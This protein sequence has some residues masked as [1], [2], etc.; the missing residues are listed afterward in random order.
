MWDLSSLTGDGTPCIRRQ[1]LAL[2]P[3]LNFINLVVLGLCGCVQAFSSFGEQ[4]QL[5]SFG[6]LASRC[7]SLSCLEAQ[8]PGSRASVVAACEFQ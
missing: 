1:S 6:A 8:A 3:F 4:G 2:S 7:S 5:S